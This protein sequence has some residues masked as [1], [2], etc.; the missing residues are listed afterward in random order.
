MPLK[1]VVE[2]IEDVDEPIRPLYKQVGEKFELELENFDHHS[3]SKA[4]KEE[5]A[6]RRIAERDL[7]TKLDA[8]KPLD[9][10]DLNEVI[11]ILDKYPELQALV[12]AGDGKN[13][14]KIDK[15]VEARLTTVKA[16]LERELNL[17]KQQLVDKDKVIGEM[18]G[19]ERIRTIHDAVREQLAKLQGFA[20]SATEDVLMYAE[21]MFEVLDDGKVVTKDAV[22]VTPGLDAAVWMS[23]MQSKKPHWFGPT[24]GGGAPG[25]GPGGVGGMN[26]W[27]NENWN[28]G[29]QA[30]ISQENPNRAEQFARAAGTKL[31]GM[32]PV[33]KK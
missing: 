15:L 26:P 31:G 21:R 8:Y 28:V 4:L 14:E 29:E 33:P 10:R 3:G 5:A 23:E 25:S 6:R 7:K 1:A 9:G 27:T 13:K 2:K 16:P 30:R 18:T 24:V 17:A 12:D 19:R 11:E 22:G 32:R 20:Q